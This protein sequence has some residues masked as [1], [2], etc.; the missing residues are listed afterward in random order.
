MSNDLISVIDIARQAG[1]RKTTIFKVMRRLG[2]V[3]TK[4]HSSTNAGQRVAYITDGERRRVLD[5][6]GAS[7]SRHEASDDGVDNPLSDVVLADEGV[8]YLLILEPDHDPGRFKV[9]FAVSM[10]ERLRHL[11]CSA[12]FAKVLR[13]WPCKQLW[14][15]TAIDCVTNGCERL[16]TEVFRAD[17]IDPV[18]ANCETFFEM[19]PRIE[20]RKGA[21]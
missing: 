12:P 8:F 11:R 17:S 3:P 20:V 21:T 10:S 14:E 16:H 13:T 1:K 6:L 5:V 4:Q 18:L 9:G 19:M 2:I 7:L 15:K